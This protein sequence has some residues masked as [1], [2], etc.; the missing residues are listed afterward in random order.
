MDRSV[1]PS[2]LAEKAAWI[3]SSGVGWIELASLPSYPPKLWLAKS[4]IGQKT[5]QEWIDI[6]KRGRSTGRRN[7]GPERRARRCRSLRDFR[8][9]E[10][11]QVKKK[12]QR[13]RSASRTCVLIKVP[14]VKA[15]SLVRNTQWMEEVTPAITRLPTVVR[16][17]SQQIRFPPEVSLRVMSPAWTRSS[18][19]F[20][21]T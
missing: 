17:R 10:Q 6:Q 12:R 20:A 13:S 7:G 21:P 19:I 18:Q 8:R 11:K 5:G 3:M 9:Q 16:R 14:R 15:C 2:I 1:S 4:R